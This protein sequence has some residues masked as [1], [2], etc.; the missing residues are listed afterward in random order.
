MK[1]ATEDER[2]R[3]FAEAGMPTSTGASGTSG[4]SGG[5]L[6]DEMLDLDADETLG[7]V[8]GR[9]GLVSLTGSAAAAGRTT[10][11]GTGGT[12]RRLSN[13]AGSGNGDGR[14]AKRTA[15]PRAN[16]AVPRSVIEEAVRVARGYLELV[17]EVE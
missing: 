1:A 13:G 12:K 15:Y 8:A 2:Q 9:S 7:G 14:S 16:L 17:C 11:N 10:M 5:G 3:V 4:A 6:G